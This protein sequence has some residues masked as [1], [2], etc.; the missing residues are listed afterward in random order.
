MEV[1]GGQNQSI[2]NGGVKAWRVCYR[3]FVTSTA[4]IRQRPR[5]CPILLPRGSPKSPSPP[6]RAAG[7][8][9]SRRWPWAFCA[10]HGANARR[11]SR[12]SR[13]TTAADGDL[14]SRLGPPLGGAETTGTGFGPT[15]PARR[16]SRGVIPLSAGPRRPF[17]QAMSSG[18]TKC[19]P[20]SL[21]ADTGV[22]RGR[23][24]RVRQF[25]LS[26]SGGEQIRSICWLERERVLVNLSRFATKS[27]F[28]SS[29][30]SIASSYFYLTSGLTFGI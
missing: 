29:N 20:T 17:G 18:I 12:R 11:V 23:P 30:K 16:A 28:N 8:V 15:P 2:S 9:S 5:T 6:G 24:T 14:P 3:G 4:P 10:G 22:V 25:C 27:S 7:G 21:R 26:C 13:A 1:I 19:A